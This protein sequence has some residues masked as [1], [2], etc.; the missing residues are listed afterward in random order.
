MSKYQI[1]TILN[2]RNYTYMYMYI[3]IYV[4]DQGIFKNYISIFLDKRYVLR[5]I[6]M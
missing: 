3:H 6:I 1:L 4:V 5:P 2:K